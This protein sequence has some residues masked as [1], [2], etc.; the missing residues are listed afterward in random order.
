[1]GTK[2]AADTFAG[3]LLL[4]IVEIEYLQL[5]GMMLLLRVKK[6]PAILLLWNSDV[7]SDT[8]YLYC[9]LISLHLSFLTQKIGIHAIYLLYNRIT[10]ITCFIYKVL[11]FSRF[12][13]K[14]SNANSSCWDEWKCWEPNPILREFHVALNPPPP[15]PT[16]HS[17]I[18]CSSFDFA[19]LWR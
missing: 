7:S 16:K 10:L 17:S 5:P 12:Q 11:K 2:V 14:L 3:L 13:R 9:N 19:Y 1:M 6:C 8:T 15:P 18:F 4:Q